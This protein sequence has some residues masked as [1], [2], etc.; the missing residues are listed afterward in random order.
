MKKTPII[1]AMLLVAGV[2]SAGLVWENDFNAANTFFDPPDNPTLIH[3]G[4]EEVWLGA[5]T[6]NINGSSNLVLTT[7][8][9]SQTRGLTRILNPLNHVNQVD[10][11]GD[12]T[13]YRFSFDILTIGANTALDVQFLQGN[14]DSGLT[15]A[16]SY[17][18]DLLSGDAA[19]LVHETTGTG[20][21]NSL[22]DVSY[23]AADNGTTVFVDFEYDGTGD[24]AMVFEAKATGG[25]LNFTQYTTTDNMSLEVIPEPATLGLVAAFGGAVIFIRRRVM[26]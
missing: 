4:R 22:F 20:S 21:F 13:F 6:A 1:S 15:P 17:N 10:T 7:G 5:N 23:T 24:I 2:A 16:N 8:G 26:I 3:D 18:I 19:E 11:T 12:A 14:R 9:S 25:P